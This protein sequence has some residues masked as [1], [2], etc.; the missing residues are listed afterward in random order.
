MALIANVD[1]FE[2]AFAFS[3]ETIEVGCC[4]SDTTLTNVT[5]GRGTSCIGQCS[6]IDAS[7]CLSGKCTGNIED[8]NPSLP[9]ND[10][11]EDYEKWMSWASRPSWVFKWCLPRCNVRKCPACCFNPLCYLH[12]KKRRHCDWKNF[13]TL[14]V[15]IFMFSLCQSSFLKETTAQGLVESRTGGGNVKN[16]KSPSQM[17]LTLIMMLTSTL[18]RYCTLA[19]TSHMN[20]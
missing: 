3:N 4:S 14:G 5:C 9:A 18:V 8:C 13:F 11:W 19:S 20:Y 2:Y 7:L 1:F 6:A 12:P 15:F 10:Y 16:K 17:T